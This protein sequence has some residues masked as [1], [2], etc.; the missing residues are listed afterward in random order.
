MTNDPGLTNAVLHNPR[1]LNRETLKAIFTARRGLLDRLVKDL[2]AK[3]PTHELIVGPR[4]M[5]KTTLLRR[6]GIAIEEDP[7]LAKRLLPLTFPEEQYNVGSLG[8][9]YLNC[10]DALADYFDKHDDPAGAQKLDA[11]VQELRKHPEA[12]LVEESEAALVRQ[13]KSMKRQLVLLVDNLSII[14]ERLSDKEKWRLRE[15]LSRSEQRP[16]LIAATVKFI[17]DTADH[18]Q[19]LYEFLHV[20][21]L[22]GCDTDEA[23]AVLRELAKVFKAPRVQD[24]LEADPARL[25]VL[26]RLAGGAPRTLVMLFQLLVQGMDGPIF[27]EL[28][29]LLDMATPLYKARF[30]ELPDQAQRVLDALALHWDPATRQDLEQESRIDGNAISSQLSRLARMGV[31]EEVAIPGQAKTTYQIA[32][33]LFNIWY[34]MRASR[35]SGHQLFCL[36]EFLKAFYSQEELRYPSGIVSFHLVEWIRHCLEGSAYEANPT[37]LLGRLRF[38]FRELVHHNQADLGVHLLEASDR[39]DAWRP[40]VAAL[41]AAGQRDRASLKRLSPEQREPAEEIYDFFVEG[42]AEKEPDKLMRRARKGSDVSKPIPSRRSMGA[43]M[44]TN[45]LRPSWRQLDSHELRILLDNRIGGPG[46]YDGKETNPDRFYLPLAREQCQVVLTY[47]DR[48]IISVEP[49]PAFDAAQWDGIAHE[50]ETLVLMGP[51]RVGRDYSFSSYRVAGSWRG[52][53]SG[54]QILPP[55]PDAP[56]AP[57]EMAEHP[58]ILEFPIQAT[59]L[60]PL[61]NHR[62]LRQHRDLTLLL[63][64]LLRGRTNLQPRRSN[65][66]WASIHRDGA[67]PEIRWVQNFYF[68]G[69]GECILDAPSPLTA[70]R[71]EV[72]ESDRY[73]TELMGIDGRGLRVPDDLDDSICRYQSLA[74]ARREEFD[75]AAYWLDV[76]SRQWHFSMSASFAALVS[77]IESLINKDGSGSKARF[78]DFFDRYAPGASLAP[79]RNKMYK[80]RSTIL[81]GSELMAIDQERD[82]GWDPF[83]EQDLELLRELWTVTR[84]AVRNWLRNPPPV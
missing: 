28:E 74:P 25:A 75:R 68:A 35:R 47:H 38:Y 2:H 26:N 57:V 76:A 83:G 58:F 79:R 46:Q 71:L 65:H 55:H 20:Q 14:I 17:S 40:L 36:V 70:E 52:D 69:L 72:I 49:G 45:L 31:V 66:F 50:I 78:Q 44:T 27:Q 82:F 12:E 8:E 9:F 23:A 51:I 73:Y 4:G 39:A 30:E 54:V 32:E 61:T 84:T 33:R 34:L 6:L 80:L 22:P 56:T 37:E 81:H 48:Q 41:R 59:D 42:L 29:R 10:L 1:Q 21:E 19:A 7:V 43:I 5:G 53:R 60:W 63:N 15:W 18:G 62:R 64:A 16:V 67:A 24:W 77:A 11:L 13:A 3:R